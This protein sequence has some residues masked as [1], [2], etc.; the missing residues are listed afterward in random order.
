M[1]QIAIQ[2]ATLQDD[3]KKEIMVDWLVWFVKELCGNTRYNFGDTG[4]GN[5]PSV[6][7]SPRD[8]VNTPTPAMRKTA[9]ITGTNGG[10]SS[11]ISIS[12][13]ARP[14][15]T[16]ESR[17]LARPVADDARMPRFSETI[18]VKLYSSGAAGALEDLGIVGAAF[19]GANAQAW[20]TR[21]RRAKSDA[22]II[23]LF[24]FTEKKD[25]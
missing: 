14:L 6:I 20:Q 25:L 13:A 22:F 10:G 1:L 18:L 24:D 12:S 5:L 2:V 3:D 4:G 21:Q 9:K 15:A 7:T 11:V 17:P 19:R 23:L 8:P 16:K